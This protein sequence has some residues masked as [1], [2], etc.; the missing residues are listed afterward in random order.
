MMY[1]LLKVLIA[2][3]LAM[4]FF[5]G[6]PTMMDMGFTWHVFFMFNLLMAGFL[7]GGILVMYIIHLLWD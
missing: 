1:R 2:G 7:A 6:L 4:F 5:L 3:Y